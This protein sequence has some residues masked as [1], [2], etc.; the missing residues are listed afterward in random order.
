VNAADLVTLFE[1]SRWA[2]ERVLRKA[3]RLTGEQLTGAGMQNAGS[4][5][6]TLVH[7]ADVEWSW[8][9]VCEEGRMPADYLT[10]EQY[11]TVKALAE[12]WRADMARTIAFVAG[13]SDADVDAEI[14]YVRPRFRPR[15]Q[16]LWHIL[17][18]ILGHNTQ[19]RAELGLYLAH[20]GHSPG[21]LD[22][23][24]FIRWR[25]NRAGR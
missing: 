22:F 5:L 9:R 7:L 11:P 23:L 8:R 10:A 24:L 25:A 17:Q 4:A 15:K 18:H 16:V 21:D 1:H 19:H 3:A 6:H 2:N 14:E 12:F 20:C 13:L